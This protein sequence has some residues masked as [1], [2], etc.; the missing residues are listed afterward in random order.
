MNVWTA[1]IQLL[2]QLAEMIQEGLSDDE[3]LARLRDPSSAGRHLLAAL[4]RGRRKIDAY[5]ANG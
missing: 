1:L 5:I 3:I 4:R 2:A